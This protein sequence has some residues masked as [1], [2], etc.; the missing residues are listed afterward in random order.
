MSKLPTPHYEL[1][2][3]NTHGRLLS[4]YVIRTPIKGYQVSYAHGQFHCR[5]DVDGKLTVYAMSE[6]N[7]GNRAIDTPAMVAASLP[8]DA[9]CHMT[10]SGRLPW[11]A[12]RLA[13][14]FFSWM[15]RELGPRG[16]RLGLRTGLTC[17][18]SGWRWLGVTANSQL[19]A[20]WSRK[21]Y[22]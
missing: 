16:G 18:S 6:W 15:L 21:E 17:L 2:R 12:R 13:D 7:F 11:S 8:H 5:L 22:A 20:R 19:I 1:C 4:D 10:N 9:F 14:N 3:N